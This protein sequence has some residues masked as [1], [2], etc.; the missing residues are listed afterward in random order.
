MCLMIV[1]TAPL[2]DREKLETAVR[3][4]AVAGLRVELEHPSRWRWGRERPARAVISEA[5]GCACSLLSD[6]ADW[7]ADAWAMRPEL[8]EPL[9]RTLEALAE[10]GLEAL[11]IEALWIGESPR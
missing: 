5:G 9:A 2:S 3:R 10:A 8:L 7:N 6:D 11:A 4:A 1:A